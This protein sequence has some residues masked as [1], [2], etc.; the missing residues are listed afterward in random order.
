MN[1]NNCPVVY[2][3][4]DNQSNIPLMNNL[5][6]QSQMLDPL[7]QM[8]IETNNNKIWLDYINTNRKMVDEVNNQ[9]LLHTIF[10]KHIELSNRILVPLQKHEII[11]NI[12]YFK[13]LPK[14]LIGCSS[15]MGRRSDTDI[16]SCIMGIL[17]SISIAMRGRY[18]VC[19]EK[20]WSEIINLYLFIAKNSGERKSALLELLKS[21]LLNHMTQKNICFKNKSGFN[22]DKSQIVKYK[23]ARE[24]EIF[25]SHIKKISKN[26]ETQSSMSELMNTLENLNRDMSPM[27]EAE[28]K[29]MDLFWDTSTLLGLIKKIYNQGEATALMEPEPSILFSKAFKEKNLTT[30]LDKAYKGES[31]GYETS[32]SSIRIEKPSINIL[33]MIQT[34][35]LYDLYEDNFYKNSGFLPR[36]LPIFGSSFIPLEEKSTGNSKATLICNYMRKYEDKITNLLELSYTQDRNRKFFEITC[37]DDAINLIKK[38]EY[39]NSSAIKNGQYS[40]MIPFMKKLHGHA[41]RI[42]G[43]IHAWNNPQPDEVPITS[44]EMEAGIALATIAR[45]HANHVFNTELKQTKKYA[46]KI[47]NYLVR[48][49]WKHSRP[50]ILATHLQQY[51]RGLN[52]ATCYPALNFL[53]QH[54]YICQYEKPGHP[55]LCILHKALLN[56]NSFHFSDD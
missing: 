46:I 51:I 34:E 47:L 5:A 26:G 14:D 30:L 44:K 12:D 16:Y 56:C 37:N 8:K 50:F 55:R 39:T 13:L 21:P 48:Q 22:V 20:Y 19:L 11:N 40:H 3:Q 42:A 10:L 15:D 43:A 24:N 38:F 31:Y 28:N 17:E 54:N 9:D 53:E 33:L 29:P 35:F 32:V 45:D 25:S 18:I 1:S 52:K 27:L 6:S 49:D 4:C 7:S 41:V 2:A 23:K 36:I